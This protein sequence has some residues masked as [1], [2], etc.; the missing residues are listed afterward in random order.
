MTKKKLLAMILGLAMAV[1]LLTPVKVFADTFDYDGGTYA[2]STAA[3]MVAFANASKSDTFSGKTVTLEAD[4]DMTGISDFPMIGSSASKFEGTFDGKGFTISNLVVNTTVSFTG[5]FAA[6]GSDALVKDFTLT[7]STFTSTKSELG[8]VAG[9]TENNSTFSGITVA[10]TVSVTQTGGS[11]YTGGLIGRIARNTTVENCVINADVK[12]NI[13]S[14]G[15]LAG[16]ADLV[17][18]TGIRIINTT[19]GATVDSSGNQCTGGF[20]GR[21]FANADPII[22][23]DGCTFSGSVTGS[24]SIGGLIG[25]R[26]SFNTATGTNQIT[27]RNCTVTGTVTGDRQV[28]GILGRSSFPI[29]IEGSTVSGQITSN[30][31]YNASLLGT[32]G[33]IGKVDNPTGANYSAYNVAITDC[34]FDGS[35]SSAGGRSGGIVG[36]SDAKNVTVSVKGCV[37][38]GTVGKAGTYMQGGLFGSI[39]NTTL[40]T[41]T[42]EDC[43]SVNTY[44]G[45]NPGAIISQVVTAATISMTRCVY[46]GSKWASMSATPTETDLQTAGLANATELV[47]AAK[48]SKTYNYSGATLVL[49]NDIDMAGVSFPMFGDAATV[50]YCGGFDGQDHEISNLNINATATYAGFF[51]SIGT[52]AVIE[53]LT[54]TDCSFTSTADHLGAVAGLSWYTAI[55]RNVTVGKGCVI[56]SESYAV[57]GIAGRAARDAQI[58]GCKV[59]CDVTGLHT[60]GGIIGGADL[61]KSADGIKITDCSVSGKVES[62]GQAATGGIIGRVKIN[63]DGTVNPTVTVTGCAVSGEVKGV[64]GDTF[65][66]SGGIIGLMNVSTVT[67]SNCFVTADITGNP[68]RQ[69]G[70]VGQINNG[71]LNISDCLYTGVINTG[72]NG[73]GIL[74]RAEN[75][76][77]VVTITRCLSTGEIHGSNKGYVLGSIGAGTVSIDS[78]YGISDR[79]SGAVGYG[80]AS[81]ETDTALFA[82]EANLL[83][84]KARTAASGLFT[85]DGDAMWKSVVGDTPQL[86]SFAS[87]TPAEI[88]VTVVAVDDI[89]AYRG[90]TNTA[91]AVPDGT[92]FAGW[93]ADADLTMP[94]DPDSAD[95]ATGTVYAKFVDAKVL[96]VMYQEMEGTDSNGK[97]ALRIVTTVDSLDLGRVGVDLS[98]LDKTR[99]GNEVTKV[100]SELT[101]YIN[102]DTQQKYTPNGLDENG[103]RLFS[104]ESLYF[105]GFNLKASATLKDQIRSGGGI[106]VQFYWVTLDG[107][108][109]DGQAR[110]I[111]FK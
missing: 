92:I 108:R 81:S 28:G 50:S 40:L 24:D 53:D 14:V 71:T 74:G 68:S 52:G 86:E 87:A 38:A 3:D 103:N 7:D 109:V 93:F 30:G 12:S 49:A 43:I 59:L 10:D 77:P 18:T 73:G 26:L 80:T 84:A 107:T 16:C 11:N 37:S 72:G 99:K 60:V 61:A 95:A 46:S 29:T 70:I 25:G 21:I 96:T 90:A 94:L 45:N 63:G 85:S 91:P 47:N 41:V 17:G 56:S 62:T 100:Y 54:F 39:N 79:V 76:A 64:D 5:V 1:C 2:I 97:Y 89:S 75:G 57:G 22:T 51:T 48:A 65:R 4:I 32:G 82:A 110:T 36:Y 35:V 104:K 23:F 27:V 8:S 19:V 34:Y 67:I 33:F 58:I 101:G 66:A 13:H 20:I 105:E 31:E 102:S 69:G 88:T 6:T 111:N 15:G 44:L 78:C 106:T 9:F 42:F 55:I 98:Y 83:G